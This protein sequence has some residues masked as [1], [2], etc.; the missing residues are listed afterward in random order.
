M[1]S[2][3]VGA[4]HLES[5][6]ASPSSRLVN[7]CPLLPRPPSHASKETG[8]N[9]ADGR[10]KG[11]PSFD[12]RRRA[13]KRMF[14][15]YV[16]GSPDYGVNELVDNGDGT[17]SDLATG[18]M[19]LQGDSGMAVGA[20]GDGAMDWEQALAWCEGLGQAGYDDWRLPDAKELQSI[21][22]YTR[23]PSATRSAAIDPVFGTSTLLDDRGRQ[24][25]PAFWSSTTHLDGRRAGDAAVYVAFGE[26]QGWMAQPPHSR[27]KQLMDV[28][29]AGAQR[30]DPKVGDPG[31]FPYGRGPQGDVIVIDNHVRCVR[32]G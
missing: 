28:H 11:Y 23:S 2:S 6:W 31:D 15:R 16:R 17:V 3:S 24:A 13:D 18:R 32:D 7:T 9:F 4:R 27:S 19:W 26:A 30:S 8:V 20:A 10:I 29:G 21:V 1:G 25:Y 22:D 14:V 12:R 5:G